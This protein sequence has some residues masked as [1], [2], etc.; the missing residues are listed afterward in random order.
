MGWA[1]FL[2]I[3]FTNASGHPAFNYLPNPQ[4]RLASNF[5]NPP[6]SFKL[7]DAKKHLQESETTPKITST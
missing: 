7:F 1:T 5:S 3:F 4:R 6:K 2:D